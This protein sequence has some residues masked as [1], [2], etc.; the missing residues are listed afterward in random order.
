[1][2]TKPFLQKN[3]QWLPA[4]AKEQKADSMQHK[5]YNWLPEDL[6]FSPSMEKEDCGVPVSR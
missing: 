5:K 3:R 6:P 2:C 1:V 4:K